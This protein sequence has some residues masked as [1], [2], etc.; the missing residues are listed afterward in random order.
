LDYLPDDVQYT[1]FDMNPNY[2]E[3]AKKKYGERGSFFCSKVAE[4]NPSDEG[5]YDIVL[6]T[7][8]LHHLNDEEALNLFKIAFY[9]LKETGYLITLDNAFIPNQA[10]IA[11]FLIEKDRGQHVRTPEGY[12]TLAKSVFPVV[13]YDI[14]NDLFRV[15]YTHIIYTCSKS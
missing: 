8:I 1:G 4:V 11:K 14:R 2:I 5:K 7:A 10:K 12:T 9:G 13:K 15:P 3:H 6:A